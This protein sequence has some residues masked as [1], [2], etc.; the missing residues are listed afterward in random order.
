MRN[1]KLALN[2]CLRHWGNVKVGKGWNQWLDETRW[3]KESTVAVN[4]CLLRFMKQDLWRGLN[5]WVSAYRQLAMHRRI[6]G[7]A[8]KKLTHRDLNRAFETIRMVARRFRLQ[9]EELEEARL[10]HLKGHISSMSVWNRWRRQQ[11]THM[12]HKL[13]AYRRWKVERNKA[14][15]WSLGHFLHRAGSRA[16]MTWRSNYIAGKTA[17]SAKQLLN[18]TTSHWRNREVC[19]A[20]T[21]WLHDYH[22]LIHVLMVMN[23][24]SRHWIKRELAKGWNSWYDQFTWERHCRS[25]FEWI[26]GHWLRRSMGKAWNKW[27][28]MWCHFKALHPL[29]SE[30]NK[31]LEHVSYYIEENGKLSRHRTALEEEIKTQAV[32]YAHD[33]EKLGKEISKLDR[34]KAE[35]VRR[36]GILELSKEQLVARCDELEARVGQVREQWDKSEA[37]L[38]D[39]LVNVVTERH[40]NERANQE[41]EAMDGHISSLEASL[42]AKISEMEAQQVTAEGEIRNLRK[43]LGVRSADLSDSH[44]ASARLEAELGAERARSGDEILLLSDKLEAAE[45]ALYRSS[46]ERQAS[47]LSAQ[48]ERHSL[49]SELLRVDSRCKAAIE[50]E[51]TLGKQLDRCKQAEGE[52]KRLYEELLQRLNAQ[53]IEMSERQRRAAIELSLDSRAMEDSLSKAHTERDTVVMKLE[54]QNEALRAEMSVLEERLKRLLVEK[55]ASVDELRGE[56]ER[57]KDRESHL[58]EKARQLQQS[59]SS[60]ADRFGMERE[61][62]RK[63][64]R[65]LEGQLSTTIRDR[66]GEIDDNRRR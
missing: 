54:G 58:E 16:Y 3:K 1:R 40:Q 8:L 23:R 64:M 20:F 22:S 50:S 33:R 27:W 2:R 31:L 24:I 6:L 9:A 42:H 45:E 32:N 10:G 18:W 7:W 38:S 35:A 61:N 51:T 14:L 43:D 5:G 28:A 66:E 17:R 36:A 56:I 48:K 13:L 39:Q 59:A 57:S 55:E 53:S 26:G 25:L 63:V 30:R 29:R 44:A 15:R 41:I 46:K 60:Q 65:E 34:E 62:D 4:R 37:E 12:F 52:S 49:E 11:E 21:T 19:R 47:A